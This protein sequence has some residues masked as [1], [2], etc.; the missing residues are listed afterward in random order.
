M[1][2]FEVWDRREGGDVLIGK[3][4]VPL[5]ALRSCHGYHLP[6]SD[7]GACIAIVIMTLYFIILIVGRMYTHTS[8]CAQ[9]RTRRTAGRRQRWGRSASSPNPLSSR[10]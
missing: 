9:T 1:F 10:P 6:A 7:N 5:L 3:A 2:T 4:R 8:F